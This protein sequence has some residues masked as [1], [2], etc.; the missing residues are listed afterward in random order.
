MSVA[1][2]G[3][4]RM[5]LRDLASIITD[6]ERVTARARGEVHDAENRLAI[7]RQERD[8]LERFLQ[9]TTEAEEP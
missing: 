8:E 4:V 7:W 6:T 2:E 9:S 1:V 5:R 3:L